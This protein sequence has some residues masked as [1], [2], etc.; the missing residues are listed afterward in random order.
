MTD[1][2]ITY[3]DWLKN[4]KERVRRVRQKIMLHANAELSSFYWE[5]LPDA[6]KKQIKSIR[7]TDLFKKEELNE[8]VEET[9]EKRG[10]EK[11]YKLN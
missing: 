9:G 4:L 2:T 11:V 1:I 3:A 5:L 7:I 8:K 6:I 10:R